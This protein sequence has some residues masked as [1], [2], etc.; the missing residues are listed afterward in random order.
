MRERATH[1]VEGVK[2]VTE[3]LSDAVDA[4]KD[5]GFVEAVE[6]A[7][8]WAKVA[9]G[10][11]AE[12]LPPLKFFT[13]IAEQLLKET[14]PEK[15]GLTACTLAYQ[16]A[17]ET[18]FRRLGGPAGARQSLAEAKEQLRELANLKEIDM[19]TFSLESPTQHDFYEQATL[20]LQVA[21]LKVGYTPTQVDGLTELVKDDFR[22]SLTKLL[23]D[24]S[25]REQFAP[26]ADYLKLGGSDEKRS[27]KLLAR[28]A[29]YQRWLFERA[30]VLRVSPFALKHVYIDTD[31]GRLKW[32]EINQPQRAQGNRVNPFAEEHGGRRPL[33]DTVFELIGS[34]TLSEALVVQGIAG[35]GKSSFTLQLCD[36]LLKRRLHPIRVRIKDLSFDKHIKD[37]LPRAVHFGDED[38]PEAEPYAFDN[39]FLND[40]IFKETGVGKYAHVCKYV[41]ILDGWDEISLSDEGFKNKAARMLDQLNE[42][43]LKQKNPR[44]R[45][46]LTGR[47]SSDLGDTKCLRDE[48]PILTIRKLTPE[49][50]EG[51]VGKLA[52]A[53][54]APEPLIEK[55]EQTETWTVPPLTRFDPIF[56][57]YREAFAQEEQQASGELDV[58]GLPLLT[59]LTVRLVAEWQGDLAPLLENTT[60]L[61]RHLIDLTCREAGKGQV[62]NADGRDEH[63]LYG[64]ELRQLLRQT[65]AA[66]TMSGEE[67]ISRKE[68][69]SRL[70]MDEDEIDTQATDLAKEVKLSSLLISF[71]FKGG[72]AHLGCEFAHKSF[73]EYLFAEAILEAL[74]H[75]GRHQRHPPPPRDTYWEDFLEGRPTDLR[76]AFS[77]KLS[78]LLAPQWLTVE[79]RKHLQHLI[80][81]EIERTANPSDEKRPGVPTAPLTWDEWKQV[82]TGLADLWQW[83]SEGAHLR[84]QTYKKR[85]VP[86]LRPA[87]INDLIQWDAPR[88]ARLTNWPYASTISIDANLG[89]SLFHLCSLV[90][91]Y[92]ADNGPEAASATPRKYQSVKE[93][94]GEPKVLFK[95]SG[96][97][98]EYFRSCVSRINSGGWGHRY[99]PGGAYMRLIDFEDA[100][101]ENISLTN[102]NLSGADL[103]G[104]ILIRSTLYMADLSSAK[105]VYASLEEAQ[106]VGAMLKEADLSGAHLF[107]ADLRNTSL[108]GARLATAHLWGTKFYGATLEEATL[109]LEQLLESY[110][111]VKELKSTEF[112]F[113][114]LD[115]ERID[116]ETFFQRLQEEQKGR[117]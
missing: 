79:V 5:L 109:S 70:E 43:Y 25:T 50:L 52:A 74:K 6:S 27:R 51:Y 48:T 92:I 100:D 73:R 117:E 110:I 32:E 36:E 101:L 40:Q 71:Y 12:A 53:V 49:Q 7:L 9:G 95:P 64:E 99:F 8:P 20:C 14:D 18:A 83:W 63:K 4:F 115:D 57:K 97:E 94:G 15:L 116:R 29:N 61:Y 19:G 24:G 104:A 10:A 28:H 62:G 82:R 56:K 30:P 86:E 44:V 41:L 65:A 98:A 88:D 26:F 54:A 72:H 85:G 105:L 84:P 91:A 37:A 13:T 87:Y 11:T 93:I 23:S 16:K 31:C 34:K 112:D 113:I 96:A 69:A 111:G 102:A 38:Y 47:P 59:Y 2:S 107:D 58:L 1:L 39:L 17:V 66:I 76:F 90:H 42:H 3:F 46:I 22:H 55:N 78:E 114:Y 106:L 68:L 35:A 21:A 75:Y 81:W 77:R 108:V 60:T 33:L 89:G 67:N 80:G 45:V 103:S